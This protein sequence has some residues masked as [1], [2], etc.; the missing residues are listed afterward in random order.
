MKCALK[1]PKAVDVMYGGEAE[2][3]GYFQAFCYH[4][5]LLYTVNR[6]GLLE[7]WN[8]GDNE[9]RL[10]KSWKTL[11]TKKSPVRLIIHHPSAQLLVLAMA[12]GSVSGWDSKG[13]FCTHNYKGSS[14]CSSITFHD[15]NLLVGREDGSLTIYDLNSTAATPAVIS[16]HV[17]AITA[18]M[19]SQDG[20][21]ITTGRDRI[22]SVCDLQ[23]KKLNRTIPVFESVED[24]CLIGDGVVAVVGD[25][26][27]E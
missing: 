17:S 2:E 19:I 15:L 14:P 13:G 22:I 23:S 21:I 12:D 6:D 16:A 1:A 8:T 27:K 9:A 4:Q 11:N 25:S 10:V 26:G 18:I 20:D 24:A 3:E 7:V 5:G